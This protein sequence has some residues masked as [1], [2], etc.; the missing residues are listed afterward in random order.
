MK[1]FKL[2]LMLAVALKIALRRLSQHLPDDESTL[3]QQMACC[4]QATSH[5]FNQC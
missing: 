3:Y 4:R 5:Y 2:I 1:I